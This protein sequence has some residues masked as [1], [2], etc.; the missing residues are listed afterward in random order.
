MDRFFNSNLHYQKPDNSFEK[1]TSNTYRK[2]NCP[3][4]EEIE[5]T[6]QIIKMFIIKNGEKLKKFYFKKTL[7][8]LQ[9]LQKKL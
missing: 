6:K 5:K 4:G 8:H 2:N 9:V 1:K 3:D 7:F